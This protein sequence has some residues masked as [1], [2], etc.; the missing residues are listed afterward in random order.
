M[1]WG[2]QWQYRGE[3]WIGQWVLLTGIFKCCAMIFQNRREIVLILEVSGGF[4]LSRSARWKVRIETFGR[5]SMHGYII[6][7]LERI[8]PLREVWI[9][10]SKYSHRG[11]V[12]LEGV[13]IDRYRPECHCI[14]YQLVESWIEHS[15]GHGLVFRRVYRSESGRTPELQNRQ[16]D[17]V[18]I[19]GIIIAGY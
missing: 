8:I 1:C 14:K 10:V 11:W 13:T 12:S 9:P 4:G 2:D 17:Q 18:Q 7:E 16:S 15:S 3:L 19:P 5:Y 6:K